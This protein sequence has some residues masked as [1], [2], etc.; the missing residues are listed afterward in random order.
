[1]I[2][3]LNYKYKVMII[4]INNKSDNLIYLFII[5]MFTMIKNHIKIIMIINKDNFKMLYNF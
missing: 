5:S 1:M 2:I 3:L 4:I